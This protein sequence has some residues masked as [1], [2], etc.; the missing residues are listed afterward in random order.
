MKRSS[1]RR[2]RTAEQARDEIL[3]AAERLL[4]EDGASALKIARIASAAHM[5]HP[6]VLHHF[7]SVDQLIEALHLR[8]SR[9]LRDDLLSLL[10]GGD[11]GGQELFLQTATRLA[12]PAK[13]RL[14]A[15]VLASGGAPFPPAEEQGLT[16]IA[17]A[18]SE[19]EHPDQVARYKVL[20]VVLAMLAESMCG[21]ELRGRLGLENEDPQRFRGWLL[22]L[23]ARP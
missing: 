23:L 19:G 16:S 8:I 9:R 17:A 13:G 1:R 4:L 3:E 14:L 21:P 22:G 20:L 7:G 2:R 12:D 10:A 18:L 5:T 6:G 11:G 15:W